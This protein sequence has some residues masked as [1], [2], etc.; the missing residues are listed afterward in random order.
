[1]IMLYGIDG[2]LYP[3]IAPLVIDLV[4]SLALL[5]RSFEAEQFPKGG[6]DGNPTCFKINCRKAK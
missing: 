4:P 3:K 1:M 5:R 6:F 2:L